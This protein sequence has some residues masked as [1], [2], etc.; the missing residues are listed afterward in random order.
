MQIV[1]CYSNP[2]ATQYLR[3]VAGTFPTVQGLTTDI[4]DE[5]FQGATTYYE[6]EVGN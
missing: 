3:T 2:Q 1:L 4:T 5:Y 6:H